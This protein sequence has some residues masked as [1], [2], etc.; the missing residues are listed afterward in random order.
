MSALGKFGAATFLIAVA[1]YAVDHREAA[2]AEPSGGG[3]S[4]TGCASAPSLSGYKRDQ[5]SNATIIVSTGKK[6]GVPQRGWV[7]AIAAAL[8]ESRLVNVNHGD[9]DS[10][11]LFQE[12]PSMGWGTPAQV[13][14]PEYAATQFYRHLLKVRGWQQ[15]SVNDAAQAVEKSGFPGAY[16]KHE[17]AARKIVASVAGAACTGKTA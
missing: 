11:G 5:M 2:D 9:R 15:M 1:M 3:A 17:Q 7:V 13:M 10:L 12:R 4:A 6:L 8:Q 14:N 16:A